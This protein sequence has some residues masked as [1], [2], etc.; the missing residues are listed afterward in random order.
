MAPYR[1]PPRENEVLPSVEASDKLT[2]YE[3]FALV[4]T[5][6]VVLVTALAILL[7]HLFPAL[8]E[9]IG[10][11]LMAYARVFAPIAVVGSMIA[12]AA[13]RFVAVKRAR[14]LAGWK[15]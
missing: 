3:R 2:I 11:A 12:P 14:K 5:A 15:E 7:T 8:D 1:T 13:Q 4:V 6:S 10:F 9:V